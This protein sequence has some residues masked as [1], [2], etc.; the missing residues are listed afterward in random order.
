MSWLNLAYITLVVADYDEA[1]KFYT[2]KLNFLLLEDSL[3]YGDQ[4][5]VV[6]QSPRAKGLCLLLK[7]ATNESQKSRIG[8]Q[9]GGDVF[10][11]L[12]TNDFERDYNSLIKRGVNQVQSIDYQID[13]TVASFADLYGNLI[14]LVE[15]R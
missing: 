6:V 5:K 2:E 15:F 11:F 13:Q 14:D 8:N 4:R 12:Q 7:K 9:T 3:T 10:L 1:I